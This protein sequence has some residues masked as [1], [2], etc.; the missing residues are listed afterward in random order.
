MWDALAAIREYDVTG[1]RSILAKA[2]ADFASAARSELYAQGACPD[3][4]LPA[5]E[6]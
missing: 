3:D 6:R 1:D 4:R 5:P 2:E